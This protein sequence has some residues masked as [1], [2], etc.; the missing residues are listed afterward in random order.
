MARVTVEDCIEKVANRFDL[1]LLAAQ[2]AHDI[3]AGAVPTVPR[4]QDK[5]TVLALREIGAG[6]LELNGI[7]SRTAA[8]LRRVDIGSGPHNPNED[9]P[10]GDD[11]PT[12]DRLSEDELLARLS[13]DDGSVALAVAED[14]SD[15]E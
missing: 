13:E 6:S 2:R 7:A 10:D 1:I 11:V 9:E 12:F 5:P 4:G 8:R 15:D 3:H 14:E